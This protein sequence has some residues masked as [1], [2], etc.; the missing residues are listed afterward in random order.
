MMTTNY[1]QILA[2]ARRLPLTE[3]LRLVSALVHEAANEVP[4]SPQTHSAMTPQEAHAA[5]ASVRAHFASQ[6]PVTPT[7]AE[8]LSNA[9]R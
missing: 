7:I 5:L 1:E 3:R 2:G 9:R 4:S 8:D 6:G